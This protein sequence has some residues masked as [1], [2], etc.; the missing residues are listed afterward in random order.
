LLGNSRLNF[1]VEIFLTCHFGLFCG[2]NWFELRAIRFLSS[3][4]MLK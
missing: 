1:Q 2:I 3:R 4:L